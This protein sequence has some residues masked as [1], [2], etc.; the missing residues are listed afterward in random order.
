MA[1][2]YECRKYGK[3]TKY[4][5]ASFHTGYSNN[6]GYL[7]LDT[8]ILDT[9]LIQSWPVKSSKSRTRDFEMLTMDS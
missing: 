9:W 1:G 3:N 8:L 2:F 7:I 6:T 4:L 5:H